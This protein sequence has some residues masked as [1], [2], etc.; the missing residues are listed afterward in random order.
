MYAVLVYPLVTPLG[1]SFTRRD[2]RTT[3]STVPQPKVAKLVLRNA[4]TES[5]WFKVRDT[6]VLQPRWPD[7]VSPTWVASV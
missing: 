7:I 3:P 5:L 6:I 4:F 1:D 2:D